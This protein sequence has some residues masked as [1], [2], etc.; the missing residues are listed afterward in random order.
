MYRKHIDLFGCV[1]EVRFAHILPNI[2]VPVF[3]L[4]RALYYFVFNYPHAY[5][6][7][8]LGIESGWNSWSSILTLLRNGH[9]KS[10]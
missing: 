3:I 5:Y 4:N 2:T 1:G 6:I 10:T 9:Q 7:L 8:M